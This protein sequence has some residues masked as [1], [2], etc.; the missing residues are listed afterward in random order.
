MKL[1]RLLDARLKQG[2]GSTEAKPTLFAQVSRDARHRPAGFLSSLHYLFL[3][4][5]SIKGL[6][7]TRSFPFPL[8]SPPAAGV[9][10]FLALNCARILRA[11]TFRPRLCI[12]IWGPLHPPRLLPIMP[13]IVND[14]IILKLQEYSACDISDALV[15][16]KVPSGG[17]LVDLV[18]ITASV[19]PGDSASPTTKAPVIAPVST[20][21]FAPKDPLQPRLQRSTP[22]NIPGSAHWV[23]LTHPGT[24][25]VMQQ[26]PG[27]T[28]A[29][30]GGIM[31]LRM[32][33]LGAKG[34]LVAGR[35]R[36]VTELESTGLPVW[37]RGTSTVGSG[38]ASIAWAIQVDLEIDGTLVRPGDLAFCDPINGIVV[39]PQDKILGVLELLPKL[40]SA[41]DKAK[42]D[43]AKGVSV[44]EAFQRHRSDL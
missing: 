36:D 22:K 29:I 24:I 42:E 19:R 15:K 21:L 3:R 16:L 26:S 6:L 34:I 38:A 1:A 7:F 8:S 33:V 13:S 14:G 43:V 30:C 5:Y 23:D 32:K 4:E 27:Q 9:E 41:D 17:V 35:V 28:N 40:T 31:A 12:W 25:V 18:P 2:Q 37:A 20:V 39:I 10:T 11:R 44:R